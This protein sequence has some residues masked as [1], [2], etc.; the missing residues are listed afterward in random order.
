LGKDLGKYSFREWQMRVR[1]QL[2]GL[3]RGKAARTAAQPHPAQHPRA[4]LMFFS[5]LENVLALTKDKD[6]TT[7]RRELTDEKIKLIYLLYGDLWLE[8]TDL[9][10]QFAE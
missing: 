9:L 7:V 10:H 1:A 2:C 6:W 3:L 4:H 8:D 5:A